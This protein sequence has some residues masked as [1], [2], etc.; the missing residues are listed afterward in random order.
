MV[1]TIVPW[2]M[3]KTAF[4]EISDGDIEFYLH[5]PKYKYYKTYHT[6]TKKNNTKTIASLINELKTN[7]EFKKKRSHYIC[8]TV[9][10]TF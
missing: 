8:M 5:N 4:K 9:N 10:T 6:Y 7:K 2:N 1:E 3:V